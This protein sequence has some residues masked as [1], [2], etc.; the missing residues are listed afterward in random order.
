MLAQRDE[1]HLK[2]EIFPA[3]GVTE[4]KS[5]SCTVYE[6][7]RGRRYLTVVSRQSVGCCGV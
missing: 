2:Y 5:P 7:C 4:K 3:G 6:G 1:M